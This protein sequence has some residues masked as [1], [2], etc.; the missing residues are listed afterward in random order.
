MFTPN[1]IIVSFY[2]K[3]V[4]KLSLSGDEIRSSGVQG[5][6]SR[7]WIAA[8]WSQKKRK[9]VPKDGTRGRGR[10]CLRLSDFHMI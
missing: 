4:G 1:R 9:V 5:S 10:D 3:I 2:H 8:D 6:S 7:I